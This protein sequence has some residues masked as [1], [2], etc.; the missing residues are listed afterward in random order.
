MLFRSEN[1][2][3]PRPAV[4]EPAPE[5]APM[6]EPIPEQPMAAVPEPAPMPEAAPEQPVRESRFGELRFGEG[7]DL[8]R[9]N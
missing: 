2:Q 5:P 4:P 8:H 6:P 9:D 3:N 1:A 7:Y